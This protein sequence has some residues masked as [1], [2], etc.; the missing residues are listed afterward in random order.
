MIVFYVVWVIVGSFVVFEL[1]SQV[2]MASTNSIMIMACTD[3]TFPISPHATHTH[4]YLD[5]RGLRDAGEICE[6]T[7]AYQSPYA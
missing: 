2:A 1:A 4:Y 5:G 3:R 6:G 7:Q